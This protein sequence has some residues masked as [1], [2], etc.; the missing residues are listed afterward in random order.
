MKKQRRFW[1]LCVTLKLEQI[2]W[3]KNKPNASEFLR[4]ELDKMMAIDKKVDITK[5]DERIKQVHERLHEL[6]VL[7]DAT[8]DET[9]REKYD[10]KLN[11]KLRELTKLR[12]E[13]ERIERELLER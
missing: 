6:S 3:L 11:V 8:R 12:K 4:A 2:Q 10:D 5:I 7:M 13:K 1:T 9:K